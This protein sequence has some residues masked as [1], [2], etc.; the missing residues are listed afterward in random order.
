MAENCLKATPSSAWRIQET[1]YPQNS[2]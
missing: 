2:D 1:Q